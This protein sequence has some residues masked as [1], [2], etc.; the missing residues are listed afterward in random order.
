MYKIYFKSLIYG[1]HNETLLKFWLECSE[2][3]KIYKILLP[4]ISQKS[5]QSKRTLI[6]VLIMRSFAQIGTICIIL[7]TLKTPMAECYFD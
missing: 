5:L 1:D 6:I 7:K 3:K 4:I 2:I